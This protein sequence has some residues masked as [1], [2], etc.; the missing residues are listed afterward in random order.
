MNNLT[1]GL[2]DK[3]LMSYFTFSDIGYLHSN[4][5]VNKIFEEPVKLD[6]LLMA[7]IRLPLDKFL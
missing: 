7:I 4:N 3:F 1:L 2:F 5:F 6:L